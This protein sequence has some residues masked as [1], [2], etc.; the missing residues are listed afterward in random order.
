MNLKSLHSVH[1]LGIGGIG[2]S[3]LARWFNHIGV[4]VSGYDRTPSPLTAELEKEGMEISYVD[5]MET[6]PGTVLQDKANTLIVWTPAMPKDSVQLDYFRDNCFHLKKRAEV[7][8][9]IT[10]GM[11]TIAVAGTHGKTTTSSM[12]AHLL[13]SGGKNIAAFLG[14]L[15]QN[16]NNNLILHDEEGGEATVV[17]EADEFDRS[18]LH[19]HPNV[20]VLTSAD[21]DHLDIYGD[22]SK[23]M[24]GFRAFIALL[25][26]KGQL[27]IHYKA[28]EKLGLS[29]GNPWKTTIYG[30]DK[31]EV[32]AE[33]IKAF[34][35]TFHFDYVGQSQRIN[36]LELRMPG[37][38]NV[39]NALAAISI[40]L[41][42]GLTASEI[43]KGLSSYKGVKRRF[44][45]WIQEEDRV[46][47]DDYA[48]HPEEIR[49]FLGSVKAMY[50]DKKLTAVFQ[51]HLFTRTRDFAKGFSESLSLADEV[52]LLEIY[53]ARE[54]PIAGVT[55]SMLLEGI[56][57]PQKSLKTKEELLDYL[58]QCKI[59]VL[60]TIGAGDIDRLVEPIANWMKQHENQI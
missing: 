40:S 1:F 7:L 20:A 17:V 9:L 48:H 45:I 44:E 25:P 23:M 41:D 10:S 16:Y 8:G 2:M 51:P 42:F 19:L 55:A 5:K 58:K 30:K 59:E 22:D 39:E 31:G 18:F 49:A 6:V 46:F 27:Y 15:T 33:N 52:I 13:K 60:V 34:P 3:A 50:P 14:G 11:P 35:G 4:K 47:I 29:G 26:E 54:L 53:P 32:R 28:F 24:D 12:I 43:Q 37:F 38:H 21:P 57:S 56:T 36:G